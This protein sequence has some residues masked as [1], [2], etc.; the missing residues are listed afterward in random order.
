[1]FFSPSIGIR[2]WFVVLT[3]NSVTEKDLRKTCLSADIQAIGKTL[4]I[5]F[6]GNNQNKF[7]VLA[8][9]KGATYGPVLTPVE[10]EE[11]VVDG[12]V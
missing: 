4:G 12:G 2:A 6:K 1:V 5:S 11:G 7:S 8:R 9:P 3:L 10:D